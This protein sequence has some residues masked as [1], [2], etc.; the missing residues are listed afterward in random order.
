M[1]LLA[2]NRNDR[3]PKRAFLQTANGM[4]QVDTFLQTEDGVV[5]YQL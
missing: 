5:E 4:V 3:Q 1:A 2:P